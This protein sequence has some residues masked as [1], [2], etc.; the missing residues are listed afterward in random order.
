[1]LERYYV[2][3]RT[4][5][6][7]R[8]L[9][10]GPAIDRYME[11]LT[12]RQAAVQT[13]KGAV[14]RLIHFNRF[15]QSRGAT[16]WEDLPSHVEPFIT[17]W[18]QTHNAWCKTAQNRACVNSQV[19]VPVEQLLRLLLPDFVGTQRCAPLPFKSSAPGF[20]TYLREERGLRPDTLHRYRHHL[21][22]FEVYLKRVD[23]SDLSAITP[24]LI[25]TF[26]IESAKRLASGGVTAR[27]GILR[28]FLRYLRRQEL[29]ATDLSRA[30]PRGRSYR[31]S[32]I[33]RSITWEEVQRVIDVVDRRDP[34]GKRDYAILLLLTGYGLRAKEVAALQ[35]DD[36]DWQHAQLHV[37]ARKGG[38]STIYP[39]SSTIGEAIIDYLRAG[40]P[41][42]KQRDLFLT[43]KSPFT[44]IMHW[45]V[46]QRAGVYIRA[47]GIQV[48]RPG[49]HTFRH[50]CVQRLVDA[51]VTLKVIGDYVGHR[52]TAS[53]QIYGKV[54][55]HKLRELVT[56]KAE[57][58]L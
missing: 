43:M 26:I 6:R 18:I 50:T 15:T 49:S 40:R 35:L 9:W 51:D 39:L 4:V 7:I 28:V 12:E 55:L 29:I 34:L 3:P 30:V 37:S 10:L 25:N 14:Q 33:P 41:D 44:P 38:H 19:R 21:R 46:S 17:D 48:R 24:A 1:M 31:Q 57:D 8:A 45:N 58:I 53:T 32:S 36:I 5:D 11:W 16:T 27:S 52:T 23:N 47:T 42:V 54:A 13:V 22:A 2:R 20:F 56:G